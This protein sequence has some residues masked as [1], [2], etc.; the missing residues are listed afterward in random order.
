MSEN[1]QTKMV[2]SDNQ[3]GL[4]L[5]AARNQM[6]ERIM[7]EGK[8]PFYKVNNGFIELGMSRNS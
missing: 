2:N 3:L 5:M 7:I 8:K 4:E 1:M 6:R